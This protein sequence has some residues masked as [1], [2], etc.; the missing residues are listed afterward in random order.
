VDTVRVDRLTAVG[1]T[2]ALCHSTVDDAFAPG[3][4]HRLDGW[5][6]RDLDVGAIVALSPAVPAGLKA[7]LQTWGPGRYDPRLNLDGVDSPI[8]LPPAYGLRDVELETYT[9]DGPISYWNAYV[10]VTQM[11]GQGSFSDPELGLS[12]TR[13]PDLVTPKLPALR[14][15]QLSLE[16]PDPPSG[17]FD[18]A[19]AERGEDVFENGCASCHDP[20]SSF[21]DVNEGKLHAPAETGMDATYAARTK[22]GQYRTTPLR[23]VWQRQPYFHDG[24][25]STLEDVV[26]HYDAQLILGLTAQEKADLVSYLESL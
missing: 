12:L 20:S 9:G 26:A 11:H 14:E 23:G 22:S 6:N 16:A 10:A 2:C 7:I 3:V 1:V 18:A 15:Y 8:I 21:T 19:A 13:D 17:S 25:A 4:G 24:S 5:P